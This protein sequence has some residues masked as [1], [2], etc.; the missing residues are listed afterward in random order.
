MRKSLIFI[1]DKFFG[2]KD[3]DLQNYL[4]R[5]LSQALFKN[6][7]CIHAKSFLKQPYRIYLYELQRSSQVLHKHLSL[8][9]FRQQLTAKKR[10]LLLQSSPFQMLVEVLATPL[11]CFKRLNFC[12]SGFS[13]TRCFLAILFKKPFILLHC[14]KKRY[15][16]ILFCHSN[17]SKLSERA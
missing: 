5:P 15:L 14:F 10:P 3:Q 11:S 17:S 7:P 16:R 13:A 6:C 1:P 8:R 9:A 2:R 4:K 12:Y